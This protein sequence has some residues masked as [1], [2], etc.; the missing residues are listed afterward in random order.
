MRALLLPLALLLAAC[1]PDADA[2]AAPE[3]VPTEPAAP[4]ASSQTVADV[5]ASTPSLSTL[6]GLIEAAGADGVLRDVDG[7]YTLFAP[8]DDAFAALEAGA[9]DALRQNPDALRALV[10]DHTLSNRTYAPD[11]F[12]EITIETVAGSEVTLLPTAGGLTVRDGT[13]VSADVVTAD[14]DADNGV[15]HVIDAVLSGPNAP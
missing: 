5:V 2:P 15:V 10:L 3:R 7:A 6:A 4:A 12:D 1:G 13:G 11:V 8:S 14:L 9:L